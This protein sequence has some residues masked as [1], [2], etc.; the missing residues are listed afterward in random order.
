[1]DASGKELTMK[2][3]TPLKLTLSR[4]TLRRLTSE[5]IQLASGGLERYPVKQP[6]YPPTS[7]SRVVCCA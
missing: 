6:D 7:D 2:K 3:N 5:Q 1:M 4:E